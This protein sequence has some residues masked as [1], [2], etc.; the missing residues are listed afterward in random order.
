MDSGSASVIQNNIRRVCSIYIV[1]ASV[2]DDVDRNT[3]TNFTTRIGI[4]AGNNPN[5]KIGYEN[6]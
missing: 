6:P 4:L 3:A 5:D 2:T 1:S